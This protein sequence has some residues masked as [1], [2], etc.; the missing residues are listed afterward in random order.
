M[1][2]CVPYLKYI[3]ATNALVCELH[4]MKNMKARISQHA[5]FS[6]EES[7]GR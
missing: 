4:S 7:W 2:V 6:L 3:H 1:V 5:R